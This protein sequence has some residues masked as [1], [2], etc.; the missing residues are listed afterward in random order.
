MAWLRRPWWLAGK[1]R[2]LC[3]PGEE[4]EHL[5]VWFRRWLTTRLPKCTP[6]W[7]ISPIVRHAG[8]AC[9]RVRFIQAIFPQLIMALSQAKQLDAGWQPA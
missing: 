4:G 8:S 6:F 1:R 2:W 9:K 3:W 7:N 5:I